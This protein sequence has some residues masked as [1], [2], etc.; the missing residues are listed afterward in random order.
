MVAL[1]TRLGIGVKGHDCAA[2]LQYPCRHRTTHISDPDKS[3]RRAGHQSPFT[4]SKAAIA[5]SLTVSSGPLDGV[6]T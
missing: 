6:P 4:V 5:A 1:L 3:N 2:L